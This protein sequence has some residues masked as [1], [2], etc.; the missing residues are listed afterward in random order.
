MIDRPPGRSGRRRLIAGAGA[1]AV[2]ALVLGA[3]RGAE[4]GTGAM[5]YGTTND[6]GSDPTTL[7]AAGVPLT[8]ATLVVNNDGGSG[9]AIHG[10]GNANAMTCHGV[11][12]YSVAGNA[13]VGMADTGTGVVAQSTDIALHVDGRA[14][15]K[16]AGTTK[17][18]A[19]NSAKLVGKLKVDAGAAILA[20]VQ[21]AP[22]GVHVV[23]ARRVNATT[24]KIFLSGPAPAL[25]RVA[26]FVVN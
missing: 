21:G 3:R 14:V 12:G 10:N 11:L 19:G 23:S 15:F 2:A 17:V 18:K 25:T 6:A 5:Q 24:I 16:Q 7:N 22:D 26:Y 8:S 1:S 13:L 9:Y 20:T 4:A